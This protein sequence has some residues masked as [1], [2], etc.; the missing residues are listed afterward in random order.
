MIA[1]F[2]RNL[3]Q[4][5]GWLL[6]A[7]WQASVLAVF[8]LLIQR[9][10]GSRLN[11]RWRYA[12]WL[13]VLLRLVLPVLPES[14]LS[15]FQFAPPRSAALEDSVTQPLFIA[16]APLPAP[17][18]HAEVVAESHPFT[19]YS[20]LAVI[21]LSGAALL[22]ILT[23]MVNR[24]F[25]HQ[26][27]KSP[28]IS[29]P[30]LWRLFTEAKAELRI[31]RTIRLIENSHVQSPA[32]MGLFQPTLLLPA[33]VREKFDTTELRFI[34]LHEL[35]HLKRGDVVVQGL[36]AVLQILHWF[37]PVLW[38][39][40]RRMRIDRE[41]AT[42]ALVLSRTGE[43]EKE[44][45]GLML[46]KL[47]EHF[48]QRHSLPTL[49]GILEDKDQFKRRFSLIAKFTIGA[50]GWSMLGIL[51]ICALSIVCLTKSKAAVVPNTTTLPAQTYLEVTY[52]KTTDTSAIPGS[53][54]IDWN[55][56]KKLLQN[57]KNEVTK[58]VDFPL[59]AGTNTIKGKIPWGSTFTATLNWSNSLANKAQ[60]MSLKMEWL[61]A[62]GGDGSY[63]SEFKASLRADECFVVRGPWKTKETSNLLISFV[64][65]P[66][67]ANSATDTDPKT[68]P[69]NGTLVELAL[70][71]K[72]NA[73]AIPSDHQRLQILQGFYGADGSWLDVT[74]LLQ[75]SVE[76]NSLKVS[77]E[78]PYTEIG[79]D[80]AYLQVKT[81][82]VSYRL[83]GVEKLATFREENFPVGLKA[84]IPTDNQ[85][86]SSSTGQRNGQIL[87]EVRV[88]EINDDVYLANK[89]KIDTAIDQGGPTMIN[90]L[91]NLKGF[92]LLSMPSVTTQP[93]TK[94]NMDIVRAFPYPTGFNSGKIASTGKK[95]PNGQANVDAVPP[96]PKEFATKDVGISAEITPSI[97]PKDSPTAGKIVLTGTLTIT[98]FKGL[99]KSNYSPV[100]LP[101]FST[102]E[103]L[104]VEALGD[105]E[106]KGIWV[107]GEYVSEKEP[108]GR[109]DK[110]DDTS[111]PQIKKRYL[112]FV[113]AAKVK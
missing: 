73:K 66:G 9:L 36:I 23:W 50:Y 24:R 54:T 3:E 43:A 111:K 41:P 98:N 49:V 88:A 97:D 21:W 30:E 25:A 52:I 59:M 57:P 14:A 15:I 6:A 91:N 104:F 28:A 99:T 33:N 12:L 90:L 32:I 86:N 58:L 44:R 48:N 34:F 112:L 67:S 62:N 7:S 46:I 85:G 65:R 101:S 61:H 40:F 17:A 78:Q 77:W 13:L 82:I 4:V 10:L 35:A 27:S 70:A 60:D 92:S 56:A 83:D 95:P 29:D 2:L 8:V 103:S 72:D 76:N 11:P 110:Y 5:F 63:G 107:P 93:G 105:H 102:S 39:A 108:G 89:E 26:V 1:P 106:L 31:H 47:L 38:F 19:F 42:D 69:T 51:I 81:L 113:S 79:G 109:D 18:F 37:N 75:K 45:Y 16:S 94:A 80:P 74:S 64:D 53:M 22:L 20:L 55:Y 100:G 96:T 71:L 87:I 84:V 68:V